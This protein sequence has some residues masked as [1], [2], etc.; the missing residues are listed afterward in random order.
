MVLIFTDKV[1]PYLIC[2]DA[3]NDKG[4][5]RNITVVPIVMKF[6]CLIASLGV[7]SYRCLVLKFATFI[8]FTVC[9]LVFDVGSATIVAWSGSFMVLTSVITDASGVLKLDLQ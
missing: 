9:A 8:T 4:T 1:S 3:W 6:L 7:Q 5:V 2:L